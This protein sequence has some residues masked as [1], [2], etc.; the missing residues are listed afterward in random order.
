MA[1]PTGRENFIVVFSRDQFEKLPERVTLQND[2]YEYPTIERALIDDLINT[3]RQTV[4]EVTG[5]LTIPGK[6]AARFATRVQNYNPQDNEEL[7]AS[8]QLK[9][10]D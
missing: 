9:H 6:P 3:S 1:P 7:I 5:R 4:K 2:E 8:L 10:G